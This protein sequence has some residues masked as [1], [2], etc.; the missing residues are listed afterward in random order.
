MHLVA[1]LHDSR[2]T[3]PAEVMTSD[4][5]TV[6]SGWQGVAR[7]KGYGERAIKVSMREHHLGERA[8]GNLSPPGLHT[9]IDG[10]KLHDAQMWEM[11]GLWE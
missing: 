6:I 10:K 4:Y 1:G 9:K 5:Q 8:I 7:T 2:E 3:P 11:Q